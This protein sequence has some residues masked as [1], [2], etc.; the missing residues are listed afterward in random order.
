MN[1]A[2]ISAGDYSSVVGTWKNNQGH[3]VV[4]TD[5]TITS[6]GNVVTAV[7]S[8]FYNDRHLTLTLNGYAID[9]Y[10]AGER[11]TTEGLI[12]N[13]DASKD[14]VFVGQGWTDG[15]DAYYKVN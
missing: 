5:S 14:R 8:S 15:S 7:S 2:Q 9:F 11:N 10:N 13:S 6:D 1:L 12:D 4:F 3:T